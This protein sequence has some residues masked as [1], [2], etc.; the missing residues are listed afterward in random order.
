MRPSERRPT[1]LW[2]RIAQW[3]ES[4]RFPPSQTQMAK[5]L[6]LSTSAIT[7]WKYGDA[8]PDLNNL[9]ALHRMTGIPVEE[10]AALAAQQT[11]E[12]RVAARTGRSAGR[13]LRDAQDDAEAGSQN[14]DD[15]EP[16]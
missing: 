7:E 2:L 8:T 1:A 9:L 11:E 5:H 16:R 10:L 13:R 4:E 12:R 14:P 15:M 6:G 3:A